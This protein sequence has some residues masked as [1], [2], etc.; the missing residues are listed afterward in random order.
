L[1]RR[2]PAKMADEF[3]CGPLCAILHAMK[4]LRVPAYVFQSSI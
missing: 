2:K 1:H 3:H 4:D